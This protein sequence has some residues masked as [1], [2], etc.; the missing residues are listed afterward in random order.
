[1]RGVVTRTAKSSRAMPSATP[2]RMAWEKEGGRVKPKP[3]Q[4][5]RRRREVG[6]AG[7]FAESG[8]Q[9]GTGLFPGDSGFGADFVFGAPV[10]VD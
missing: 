9:G 1:M 7:A 4:R 8:T 3:D 10:E 5:S 6:R 2:M